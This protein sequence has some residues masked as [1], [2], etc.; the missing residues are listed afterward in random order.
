M[1]FDNPVN[2]T[3]SDDEDLQV[4][5]ELLKMIERDEK[6]RA[7]SQ[8]PTEVFN[9]GD[10]QDVKEVKIGTLFPPEEK[11]ELVHLLK[12][13]VDVFAWSYQDMPGLSSDIVLH[14]IPL[15]PGAKPVRQKLRRLKPDLI[16]RVKDEIRKLWDAG[17]LGVAEY[18]EW[19]VNIVPVEKKESGKLRVCQDYRPL[20][21]ASPKDNFPL[22]HIDTLVD[23][24]AGNSYFSFMDG[25]SGYN[26]IKLDPDDMI[27]TAFITL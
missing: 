5:P 26:Q 10:S 6:E 15:K 12:E 13:Y 3:D 18:T 9:L 20:N 25:F 2:T 8:E 27:K 17:F 11:E 21:E 14:K 4:S 23:N 22:P 7:T 16:L 19:V 24:T 1:N